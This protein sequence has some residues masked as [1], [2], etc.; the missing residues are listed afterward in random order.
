MRLE[1]PRWGGARLTSSPSRS[2]T[3]AGSRSRSAP[4]Y[5]PRYARTCACAAPGGNASV[6]GR[7][8]KSM[9]TFAILAHRAGARL[10]CACTAYLCVPRAM[11]ARMCCRRVLPV[12]PFRAPLSFILCRSRLARAPTL[13]HAA[14]SQGLVKKAIELSVLCECE[15]G[16]F[17]MSTRRSHVRRSPRGLARV[18][19]L[20]WSARLIL[21]RRPA[22]RQVRTRPSWCSTRRAAR[23]RWRR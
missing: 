17:V 5:A 13:A 11:R 22:P 21:A 4:A 9:S 15:I 3:D 12:R 10:R 2:T 18:R 19:A 1:L 20:P 7:A 16:L 8:L 6:H 14:S 23:S